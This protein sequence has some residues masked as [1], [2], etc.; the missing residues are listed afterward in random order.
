M[1]VPSRPSINVRLIIWSEAEYTCTLTST[2]EPSQSFRGTIN[3][4]GVDLTID[5]IEAMAWRVVAATA[6]TDPG[7]IEGAYAGA[8]A[9]AAIGSGGGL[10]VLVGGS[11]DTITLQ[12][13]AVTGTEGV[14]V[15]AGIESFVL[16]HQS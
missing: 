3:K 12:P 2:T 9:D 4:I 5:K 1:G 10:R 8:S 13:L 15:S 16:E 7:A 14:G 11:G 6:D